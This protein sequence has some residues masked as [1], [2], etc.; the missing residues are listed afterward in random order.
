MNVLILCLGNPETLP[1]P[2]RNISYLHKKKFTV[3]AVCYKYK[4]NKYSELRKSFFLLTKENFLGKSFIRRITR[5]LP[6]VTIKLSNKLCQFAEKLSNWHLNCRDIERDIKEN[7]YNYILVEDLYLLPLS[8]R[9]CN[10]AR[11][12]FDAREYYTKQF[13]NNFFWK[14][15]AKPYREYLCHEYLKKCDHI[16]TVSEG[17]SNEFANEFNVKSSVVRSTPEL[18]DIKVTKTIGIIKLVHHGNS[19]SNRSIDNLIKIIGSVSRKISLDLYLTGDPQNINKIK[20]KASSY[21]NINVSEPLPYIDMI[22]KLNEY[23]VGIHFLPPNGFNL[24]HC[25][26]NKFFEFIQAR[27]AVIIGPSPQMASV[28]KKYQCGL[29]SKNFSNDSMINLLQN[30]S[31]EEIDECKKNS[32]TAALDLCWEK[33]SQKLSRFF[34]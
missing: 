15:L 2:K 34:I 4:P 3:D 32:N 25:L 20:K 5:S 1:R 14:I 33:E 22:P 21:S 30:I 26:P 24:L 18:F 6:S 16:I 8:F 27:L 29:I 17:I 12:I 28:I 19:N 11:L 7:K 31:I 13:E 10:G 23:D 9:V